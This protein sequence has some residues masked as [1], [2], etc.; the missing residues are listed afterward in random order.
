VCFWEM[1]VAGKVESVVLFSLFENQSN[2]N[3]DL[4]LP[5]FHIFVFLNAEG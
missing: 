3:W 4:F 2:C 5:V 1:S